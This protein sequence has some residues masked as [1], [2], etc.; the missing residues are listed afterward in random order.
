MKLLVVEDETVLLEKYL[1]YLAPLYSDYKGLST[2]ADAIE[3]I[4]NENFDVLL[5]DYNLPDGNGLD[6]IKEYQKGDDNPVIVMITA[7]SKES[8]AIQSLN[9]GV[10]KYIEKPISKQELIDVMEKS[11]KEAEKRE[12]LRAL[13]TQ[14]TLSKLAQ[15]R[16]VSDYFL[17]QREI[18]VLESLLINNKNSNV[19]KHLFISQGTVRNHLSNVFQKL[20]VSNKDELRKKVKNLN[21]KS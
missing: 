3:S 4:N 11:L 21:R 14:F 17:T 7:Y 1:S 9:L 5:V 10:Y 8:I 19:A 12:S 13:V 20:H 2:F 6:L 18:E 15:D 16:L